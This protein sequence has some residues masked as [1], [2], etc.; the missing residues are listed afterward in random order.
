[1]EDHAVIA[2]FS[3][4][5]EDL[6]ALYELEDLLT[7]KIAE[8]RVGE[9]DGNEIASDLSDGSFYMYGPDA[10]KLFSAVRP[11]LEAAACLSNVRV[12]LRYGPPE[13]GVAERTE[14]IEN[15]D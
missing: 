11:L 6:E 10:E 9:F 4:H 14:V 1:M 3:Y 12:N 2:H 7:D 5:G 13:D 15:R 8:L